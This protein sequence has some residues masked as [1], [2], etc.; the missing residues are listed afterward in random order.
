MAE[1]DGDDAIGVLDR[2]TALLE[3][4]E[5]DDRGLGISELALRAGLPKSTVSRLVAILVRRNYLERDGRLLHLGLRLFELGHLAEQPRR[6]RSAAL[7]IMANLRNTTGGTVNVAIRDERELVCIA[8]MRGQAPAPVIAHTG[9]F[10]PMHA[11]ALGKAVLAH[12][13][14]AFVEEILSAPLPAWTERTLTDPTAL[15]VELDRIGRGAP[16]LD[17][18]EYLAGVSCVAHGLF[19]RSGDVVGALSVSNT[20]TVFDAELFAPVVHAAA[21]ALTRRLEEAPSGDT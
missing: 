12:S 11:T 10:L 14:A 4:F 7:P 8:V 17:A 1:A 16:A 15:R 6:L 2:L 18:G 19:D 21:G 3:A 20:S 5:S 9:A 13:R